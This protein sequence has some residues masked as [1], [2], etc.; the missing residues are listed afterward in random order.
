[1]CVKGPYLLFEIDQIKEIRRR[2]KYFLI[3]EGNKVEKSQNLL[4]FVHHSMGRFL[5]YFFSKIQYYFLFRKLF[6]LPI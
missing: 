3:K 6:K 5:K 1:M 4:K 2:L